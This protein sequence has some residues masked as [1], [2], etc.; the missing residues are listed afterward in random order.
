MLHDELHSDMAWWTGSGTV[1]VS[2]YLKGGC[3]GAAEG[4]GGEAGAGG[5]GGKWGDAGGDGS[6][7]G[8]SLSGGVGGGV[9][10]SA[11]SW[12]WGGRADR[13][14]YSEVGGGGEAGARSPLSACSA[15]ERLQG[16]EHKTSTDRPKQEGQVRRFGKPSEDTLHFLLSEWSMTETY[17][18]GEKGGALCSVPS[19]K[20]RS[21]LK[22]K[23]TPTILITLCHLNNLLPNMK[24]T[25]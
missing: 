23:P 20:P 7:S 18:K 4:R 5:G 1:T 21:D 2:S 16:R 17:P 24:L 15:W 6:A 8:V 19:H 25:W 3:Q 14:W 11:A 13:K 22:N 12:R 9:G 10:N